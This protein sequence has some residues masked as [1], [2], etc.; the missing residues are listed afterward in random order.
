MGA[1]GNYPLI[2]W[3]IDCH[4]SG[5]LRG[6]SVLYPFFSL[7]LVHFDSIF[8]FLLAKIILAISK[9]FKGLNFR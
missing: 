9:C 6:L 4:W 2:V 7:N 8:I 5:S 3:R 1:K